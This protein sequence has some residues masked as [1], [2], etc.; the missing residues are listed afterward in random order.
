VAN[1]LLRLIWLWGLRS[2]KETGLNS[3]VPQN[4]K[5]IEPNTGLVGLFFFAQ[6]FCSGKKGSAFCLLLPVTLIAVRTFLFLQAVFIFKDFVQKDSN[7]MLFW[8]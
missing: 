5:P 4:G 6:N 2:P 8:F 3:Q 1:V 7:A